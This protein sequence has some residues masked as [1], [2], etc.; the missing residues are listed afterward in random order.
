MDRDLGSEVVSFLQDG[1]YF[2]LG[3]AFESPIRGARGS[4]VA[5]LLPTT[6]VSPRGELLTMCAHPDL[7]QS[8]PTADSLPTA[9]KVDAFELSITQHS[10]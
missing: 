5:C 4:T 2:H 3:R 10:F 7:S 8:T 6:H 1:A 9:A